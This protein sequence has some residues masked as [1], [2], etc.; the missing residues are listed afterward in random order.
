VIEE[1]MLMNLFVYFQL[2]GE[3]CSNKNG[4]EVILISKS[5]R[6][7]FKSQFIM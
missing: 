7:V 3:T 5:A 2:Q 1:L 4:D 6:V